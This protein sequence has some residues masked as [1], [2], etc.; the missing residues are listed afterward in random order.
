MRILINDLLKLYTNYGRRGVVG[1]CG[2][3]QTSARTAIEATTW[4]IIVTG[5]HHDRLHL[6]G[7]LVHTFFGL[8]AK[9]SGKFEF[10]KKLY[11]IYL[12]V[13]VL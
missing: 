8:V 6:N 2:V 9:K 1:V 13:L 5:Q 4:T 11:T 3:D 12:F 7:L 10:E